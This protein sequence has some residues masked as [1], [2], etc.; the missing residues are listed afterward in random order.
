MICVIA[1]V[2]VLPGK[3]GEFEGLIREVK[4]QVQANEPGNLLYQM[5]RSQTE[6][7]SYKGIEIY[8]DQAAFDLHAQ[9]DYFLAALPKLG[10]LLAGEPHVEFL[11]PVD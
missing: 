6:P 2:Q 1:N 4:A 5:T 3:G 11:D 7:N 9:A 8:R 10:P